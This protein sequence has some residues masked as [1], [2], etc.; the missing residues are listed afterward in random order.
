VADRLVAGGDGR[1][2]RS[3]M[4]RGLA[5]RACWRAAAKTIRP[6]A[7]SLVATLGAIG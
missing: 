5:Q 4:R 2:D 3:N 1:G 6:A 7:R